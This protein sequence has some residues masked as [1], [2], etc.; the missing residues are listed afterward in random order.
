MNDLLGYLIIFIVLAKFALYG[1]G[2]STSQPGR[3]V[4]SID[5]NAPD[6]IS[7]CTTHIQLLAA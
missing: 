7:G 5:V 1:T 6:L 3:L 4:K 2:G